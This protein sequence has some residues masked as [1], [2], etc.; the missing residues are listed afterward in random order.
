MSRV[1]WRSA[2]RTA[3]RSAALQAGELSPRVVNAAALSAVSSPT[4]GL[5]DT[6]PD[7]L[8]APSLIRTPRL[9]ALDGASDAPL[10]ASV[11]PALLP[12]PRR[13]IAGRLSALPRAYG[14]V[15]ALL[16]ILAGTLSALALPS[17]VLAAEPCANAQ[18]R[19]ESNLNAA[20]G[21]PYSTQLPDCRAYELVSPPD[22]GGIPAVSFD[23]S[24]GDQPHTGG[25][26][27]DQVT[28][29]GALYWVSR[30]T[31]A[32]TGAVPNGRSLD[33]F[34]S[35]R[36]TGGWTTHDLTPFS[37]IG[38]MELIAGAPDGST[39]LILT[40]T[41]LVPEDQDNPLNV[42]GEVQD[43]YDIYR[44]SEGEAPLLVSHGIAPRTVPPN[45]FAEGLE[46]RAA[47]P[48][49]FSATLTAVAFVSSARLTG[50]E[51]T[52]EQEA[53]PGFNDCYAWADVGARLAALTNPDHE[54]TSINGQKRNCELL[55]MTP[56]G[57][58][59][60][61]DLGGDFYSG[62]IFVGNG[63]STSPK[64]QPV[65]L[66][67]PTSTPTMFDAL[68]PDG[69]LAYV[70]TAYPLGN[71]ERGGE[72]DVYAVTVP[73]FPHNTLNTPGQ[74][75][76]ENTVVCLSCQLGGGGAATF[77]GQS[78][79][80]SHVF[81]NVA[82]AAGEPAGHPYKG[83]WSWNRSGK[84][85]AR[86]TEATDVEQLVFSENGQY[87]A[88]LTKQLANNPNGTADVYE[89]SAG[90][91]PKLITSGVSADTYRL[92]GFGE[93]SFRPPTA[94]GVSNDGR[95]V[96][97]D[98]L[99]PGE[100]SLETL[101]EWNGEPVPVQLSP[102]GATS[103][104]YVLGTAGPEL[105]DIFFAAHE[106]LVGADRNGGTQDVYDA[107]VQ[108]GFSP[109]TA[110]NPNP[111]PG[112]SSC[113]PPTS[114]P[115]PQ[116][117]SPSP[118]TAGLGLAAFGLAPLPP[119]TSHPA[120]A[121]KPLTRA[122]KLAKALKACKKDKSKSKRTKCEKEARKKYAPKS[123]AKKTAKGGK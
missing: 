122:Q 41:S 12:T 69:S 99:P 8:K 46:L 103:S 18:A 78:A 106:P 68:S 102:L 116:A 31:P 79:D 115:N 24:S 83:L 114:T 9:S 37:T 108:G 5:A 6:C 111:S 70:T 48:I 66:S 38:D 20:T 15:L 120:S 121:V 16:A 36:A 63:F 67:A 93:D 33:V 104:Y 50:P 85:A 13:P 27:W 30:A 75:G 123:K 26:G 110:G 51:M 62:L 35:R 107:R 44:V 32:G 28:P 11:S 59:V 96:V 45:G 98:D 22:T 4:C 97:Y 19:T 65:Q 74:T 1:V 95:R 73:A 61:R 109:C 39:S 90:Q 101:Q 100:G 86:L 3:S 87:A 72:P 84:T 118:Y 57:R 77:A 94:A 29:G 76:S 113:S 60:F 23:K 21:Q 64:V 54:F 56:D 119:D 42:Q 25:S 88:G 80:G 10:T 71:E 81:F 47:R 17:A 49:A 112:S 53:S 91:A 58:P 82:E 34:V 89:F 40:Q 7:R 52:P 55:G 2:A 43:A 117:P 105:E 92:T 14:S